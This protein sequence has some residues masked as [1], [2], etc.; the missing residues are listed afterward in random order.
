MDGKAHPVAESRALALQPRTLEVLRGRVTDRLLERGNRAVRLR[1]HAGDRTATLPLFDMGMD[2]TAYPF[3][4][5]L[6]QA[7][8]EEA[9][10][11]HLAH[12]QV[13]VDW[14]TRLVA[15]TATPARDVVCDLVSAAGE[16]EQVRARYLVGCDGAHSLVR[17]QAGIAFTGG[18]YPQTF[19]LADADAEGLD[20]DTAHVWFGA[21][22][23]LFFFPLLR[24]AAWRLLTPRPSSGEETSPASRVPA[25]EVRSL[26]ARWAWMSC[27]R[28]WIPLPA[29]PSGS[30][31]RCGRPRSRSITGTRTR[32]G[33][34]RCSWPGM[35]RISTVPPAR[36]A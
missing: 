20:P 35:P 3:L 10:V 26:P 31:P 21:A 28:S 29:A 7:E 24:P 14:N 8:T 17:E 27:K 23:P 15:Y 19:L 22:G 33:P 30:R 34:G 11:D 12:Q 18:R 32:T 5:F 4:L 6:S 25:A 36:R 16:R 9:P 2:D 1:W 13:N